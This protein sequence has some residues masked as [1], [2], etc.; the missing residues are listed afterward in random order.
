MPHA[1]GGYEDTSHAHEWQVTYTYDSTG[2]WQKCE[3]CN[4]TTEKQ[5]HKFN[6]GTCTVC[7][8]VDKALLPPQKGLMSKYFS[9]VKATYA[10]EGIKDSDGTVKEFKNLV[11]R[12]IDVLAQDILIRL[13]YVYGDLR[14][15]KSA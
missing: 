14:T 15:T 5:S 11:D 7:G 8:Y 2:H 10:K 9:G 6:Q 1:G 4:K 12:Q 3:H 13:N